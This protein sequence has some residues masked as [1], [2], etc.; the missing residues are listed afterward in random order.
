MIHLARN[1]VITLTDGAHTFTVPIES[2][3]VTF[4]PAPVAPKR[5][6]PSLAEIGPD[7]APL[8]GHLIVVASDLA[9]RLGLDR[10]I[11]GALD[12]PSSYFMKSPPRQLSDHDAREATLDFI[13]NGQA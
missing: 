6:I 7:D 3:D 8:L 10:G 12:G 5:P 13:V 1:T 11:G 4:T 9:R 2:G